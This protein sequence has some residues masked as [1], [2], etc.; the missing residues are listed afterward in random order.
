MGL[1]IHKKRLQPPPQRKIIAVIGA[2]GSFGR[3]V[4]DA[5]YRTR[6]FQACIALDMQWSQAVKDSLAAQYGDFLCPAECDIT[7]PFAVESLHKIFAQYHVNY[8]VHCAFFSNPSPHIDLAHELEI[9]GTRH[10]LQ[11]TS[12]VNI[13]KVVTTSSVLC[14]GAHLDHSSWIEEDTTF[15]PPESRMLKDRA[16][17]DA[18]TLEYGQGPRN[19]V[20]VVA[21]LGCIVPLSE[22]H[23]LTR[24]LNQ[25][26]ILTALGYDP[27]VQWISPQDAAAAVVALT[28]SVQTHGA[29]NIV[30]SEP[31]SLSQTIAYLG[32]RA[33]PLPLSSLRYAASLAWSAQL[34]DIPSGFIDFLKYSVV[35][36]PEKLWHDT[37]F[38][39]TMNVFETLDQVKLMASKSLHRGIFQSREKLDKEKNI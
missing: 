13:K 28:T 31:I 17:V 2:Q 16:E 26:Y 33:L 12:S 30:S 9:I 20:Y 39:H 37:E 35:C 36:S 8:V 1:K 38:H 22:R 11:A 4:V 25:P 24:Y 5:V 10:I 21:R 29:Y 34:S 23:F 14:Y 15:R 7:Q 27:V 32:H 3:Y 18:M 6:E 19:S